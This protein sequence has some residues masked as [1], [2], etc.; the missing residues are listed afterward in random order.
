M[1]Q[2]QV[3]A[4]AGDE[5]AQLLLAQHYLK[6]AQLDNDPQPRARLAVSLLVKSSKQGSDEATRLLADCLEKELGRSTCSVLCH[7]AIISPDQLFV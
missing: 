3:A 2:W 6:L 1:S 4:D 5:R 7:V